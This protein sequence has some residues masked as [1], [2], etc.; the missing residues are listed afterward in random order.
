VDGDHDPVE[1][2]AQLRA[3]REEGEDRDRQDPE[4]QE[5]QRPVDGNQAQYVLIAQRPPAQRQFDLI[6]RRWVTTHRLLGVGKHDPGVAAQTPIPA[7]TSVSRTGEDRILGSQL[8]RVYAGELVTSE[9]AGDQL[10]APAS[11]ATPGRVST[12]RRSELL[13]RFRH[14]EERTSRL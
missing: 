5:M 13:R 7:V 2:A 10:V 12:G 1:L 6:T 14:A 11:S 8:C 9:A 4:D 3:V